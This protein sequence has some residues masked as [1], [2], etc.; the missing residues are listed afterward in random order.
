M[1]QI[2]ATG[3]QKAVLEIQAR[4]G[5]ENALL[6]HE[7]SQVQMLQGIAEIVRC[8]ATPLTIRQQQ[9]TVRMFRGFDVQEVDTFLE[10]AIGMLAE[11]RSA[12]GSMHCRRCCARAGR[13]RR[14][15]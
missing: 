13:T 1:G 10:E 4:I 2:N 7:M 8:R 12:R 15:P 6:A 3:D 5:A 9:F 11:L 14:R